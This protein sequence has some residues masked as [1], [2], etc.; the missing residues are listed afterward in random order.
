MFYLQTF[1]NR[2]LQGLASVIPILVALS[3]LGALNGGFFGVP[4]QFVVIAAVSSFKSSVDKRPT[5]LSVNFGVL[6]CRMLFVG[7]REG[8][9]PPIFSMIH[10]R[11]QTPLPAVLLMVK[12]ATRLDENY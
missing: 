4:R 3:C 5:S 11:R 8:H 12:L 2:A 9:W 1:A 7:A 10:I 6:C